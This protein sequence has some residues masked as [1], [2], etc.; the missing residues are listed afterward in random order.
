MLVYKGGETQERAE[1]LAD[2]FS[3]FE[4]SLWLRDFHLYQKWLGATGEAI[5]YILREYRNRKGAVPRRVVINHYLPKYYEKNRKSRGASDK[6]F[7]G[8]EQ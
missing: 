8:P 1:R 4:P 3:G 5:Y 7:V 2:G 6:G